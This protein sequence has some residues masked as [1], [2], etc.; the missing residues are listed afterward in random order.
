MYWRKKLKLLI[1]ELQYR[2]DGLPLWICQDLK[3]YT[4][5][6]YCAGVRPK[7][8][9]A[10]ISINVRIVRTWVYGGSFGLLLGKPRNHRNSAYKI[11]RWLELKNITWPIS[12]P[13]CSPT[14]RRHSLN[15][16]PKTPLARFRP[17]HS[18]QIQSHSPS[19]CH[20]VD[21]R[22]QH[23]NLLKPRFPNKPP[24]RRRQLLPPP[25]PPPLHRRPRQLS[26][27]QSDHQTTI[28]VG[29]F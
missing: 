25:S 1:Y 22:I 15:L 24:R 26:N 6:I 12:P 13:L 4:S 9:L 5:N 20:N 2:D 19:L 8:S 10:L 23:P 28:D 27:I 18:R 11:Q 14:Q 29:C 16:L 3:P 17:K 21:R 7:R